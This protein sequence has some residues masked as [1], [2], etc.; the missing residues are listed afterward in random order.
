MLFKEPLVDGVGAG[1]GMIEDGEEK[2]ET[3][4]KGAGVPCEDC[5]L[6]VDCPSLAPNNAIPIGWG[7]SID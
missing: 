3:S 2:A 4:G 7:A 1:K 5:P 6:G